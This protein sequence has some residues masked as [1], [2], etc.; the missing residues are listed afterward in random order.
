MSALFSLVAFPLG[1]VTDALDESLIVVIAH[2]NCN[3]A[4]V[5]LLVLFLLVPMGAS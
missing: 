5:S 3:F 4:I 2:V 1:K